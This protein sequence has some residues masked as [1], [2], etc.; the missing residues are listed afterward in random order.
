MKLLP[1]VAYGAT[2]VSCFSIPK[3]PDTKAAATPG[4]DVSSVLHTRASDSSPDALEEL[5]RQAVKAQKAANAPSLKD[6]RWY[7]FM[8]CGLPENTRAGSKDGITLIKPRP[9]P[10]EGRPPL[11]E[12]QAE[13]RAKKDEK[14]WKSAQQQVKEQTGCDHVGFIVGKVTTT[15]SWSLSKSVRLF[16]K[17]HYVEPES[18]LVRAGKDKG[19]TVARWKNEELNDEQI[20]GD[21]NSS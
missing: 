8:S 17:L 16:A 11:A 5:Y 9:P 12:S 14:V 21:L 6:K 10:R 1:L 20:P 4:S 2:V 19:S 3:I 18:T 13:L 15:R 7:Y